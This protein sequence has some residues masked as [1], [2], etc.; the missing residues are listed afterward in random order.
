VDQFRQA[1]E[2]FRA[3]RAPCTPVG[4]VTAAGDAD[5]RVVLT[6]LAE[7]LEQ[8]VDMRTVVIIGNSTS[9][10]IGGRLVTPRGYT[11]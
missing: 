10:V 2:I 9:R 1:V 11:L 4:L 6:T 5:Q 7:A 8:A 3:Q